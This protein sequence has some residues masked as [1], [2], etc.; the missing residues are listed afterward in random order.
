MKSSKDQY[1]PAEL[2]IKALREKA[3]TKRR[4]LRE[5][6][7]NAAYFVKVNKKAVGT[8]DYIASDKGFIKK[9]R[10]PPHFKSL[11][12]NCKRFVFSKRC[13]T[14]KQGKYRSISLRGRRRLFNVLLVLLTNCD[15]LSGQVGK[16]K[17]GHMDT[18]SHD[19]MMLQYARR[20]GD[21]ISSSTWY[22]YIGMLDAMDIY[23]SKEIKLYGEDGVTVRSEASYKWLS[24][25]FLQGIGAFTDEVMASI[26][27]SY[28]KA[29]NKGLSFVWRE[30]NS[31][32]NYR[33]T[34]DLF[35][36]YSYGSA[37]PQ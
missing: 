15:F 29:V 37:P 16:P 7:R 12:N 9:N 33:P 4:E 11:I 24:K 10:L 5:K 21:A 13:H 30:H 23:F 19:A 2:A 22:R 36:P 34:P 28:Q 1:S 25:S 27:A 35:T 3:R 20:F 31:P 14:D 8:A 32:V 17:I 26:K 6:R 18:T